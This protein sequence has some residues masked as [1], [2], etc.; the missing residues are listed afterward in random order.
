MA[1]RGVAS[2]I[3][4]RP[5]AARA[6]PAPRRRS[7]SAVLG[8][9]ILLLPITNLGRIPVLAAG[10]RD[11][12][13][14]LNDLAVAITLLGGLI[15]ALQRRRFLL[16]RASGLALAFATV[17]ALSA[18]A[19]VPRFGLTPAE[20]TISLAYLVR[21]LAYFG[22]YLVVINVVTATRV[23][24][25]WRRLEAAIIAFAIFGIVQSIFLPGFAQLVDP[26]GGWDVQGH[27]LVSTVLDP[28]FAGVMLVI[29]LL[30]QLATLA[31]GGRV[32][33]WKPTVLVAA[34][35]MTVSRSSILGLLA[36]AGLVLLVRGPSRKM[37]RIAVG[38]LIAVVPFGPLIYDFADSFGRFSIEGSAA[39]RFVSWAR[40]LRI[41]A[42][43]PL[44]GVGF[45]TYGFAQRAY[46][47][48]AGY[49]SDFTLDGG[50]LFVAVLTGVVGVGLYLGLLGQVGAYAV[51]VWQDTGEPAARRGLALGTAAS[52]LAVLVH[53]VFLNSLLLTYVMEMLWIA[54]GLVYVMAHGTGDDRNTPARIDLARSGG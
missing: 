52:M 27:R 20:L 18:F 24:E 51:R 39:L 25:V 38:L 54:G 31:F 37:V 47:Y 21:W 12:P 6:E 50:L 10:A 5:G 4:L 32:P 44:I 41:F 23:E 19:A 9:A 49:A 14:V 16:D 26:D 29:P 53:S 17:G 35:L 46:G 28:N 7:A 8:L 48:S 1:S 34:L 3:D 36:G 15:V 42:D 2:A 30:V 11:V 13:I 43:N 40:A 33:A 45:N 22:I